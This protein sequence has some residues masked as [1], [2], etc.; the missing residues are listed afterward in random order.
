MAFAFSFLFPISWIP[1]HHFC[2]TEHDSNWTA[3][4]ILAKAARNPH[5][6]TN[7]ILLEFAWNLTLPHT[8]ANCQIYIKVDKINLFNWIS[9][10]ARSCMFCW[11]GLT[12][13]EIVAEAGPFPASPLQSQPAVR[14]AVGFVMP[15]QEG[16]WG[17]GSQAWIVPWGWAS[18]HCV[19]SVLSS[20]LPNC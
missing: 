17:W 1:N 20:R 12:L 13:L 7:P 10:F 8:I 4:D 2:E 3:K 15:F 19:E 9:C 14:A 6:V 16:A 18:W 5:V 11:H